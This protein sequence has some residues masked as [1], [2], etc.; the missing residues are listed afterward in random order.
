MKPTSFPQSNDTLTGGP[1]ENYGVDQETVPDL[2][3]YRGTGE[4]ISCWSFDD[5]WE[6]LS[7]LFT[8]RVFLRV[9]GKTHPP[10]WLAGGRVFNSGGRKK[11]DR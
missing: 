8:G 5:W 4:V 2:E 6:R 1:G 7:V 3:I 11:G 9:A 10:L